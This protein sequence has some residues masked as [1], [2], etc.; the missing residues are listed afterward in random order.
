MA[1]GDLP[2]RTL[3]Y[4]FSIACLSLHGSDREIRRTGAAP[5]RDISLGRRRYAPNAKINTWC[6]IAIINAQ[7]MI[8]KAHLKKEYAAM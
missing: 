1:T 5:A 6:K 2:A 4:L 8:W 7:C 3:P